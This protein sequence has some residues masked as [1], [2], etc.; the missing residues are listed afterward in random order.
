MRDMPFDSR[1]V[2]NFPSD[3]PLAQRGDYAR[4]PSSRPRHRPPPLAARSARR[5]SDQRAGV[6]PRLRCWQCI[7]QSKGC[8]WP[9]ATVLAVY[10]SVEGLPLALGCGAGSV[11]LSRRAVVGPWLRCWQ[12]ISQS[13]GRRWPLA[14]V[15]AV[16][17]SVEWLPLALGCGAGS[18]YLSR[19]AVVGSRLRCWQGISQWKG[20]RW[21]SAAVLAVYVSVEWLPLALGCGAGIA[22]L[23]YRLRCRR[24][25]PSVTVLALYISVDGLPLALCD[26]ALVVYS[27]CTAVIGPLGPCAAPLGVLAC[28]TSAPQ[29]TPPPLSL[30]P[31]AG[32]P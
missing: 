3:L 24:H 31:S 6:G 26:R 20:C 13:K 12:C 11:Y 23:K 25:R 22:S 21:L 19:R 2:Q 9:S 28:A 30:P 32:S 4:H 17:I 7:S 16:Y 29:L 10:I 18:V 15:L 27:F 14:T 5:C 1:R 8:R